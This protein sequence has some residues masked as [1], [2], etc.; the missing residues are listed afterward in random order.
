MSA[1]FEYRTTFARIP[2]DFPNH[3]RISEDLGHIAPKPPRSED[4]QLVTATTVVTDSGPVIF[5]FWE[6]PLD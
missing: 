2:Q 5:Y 4:W 1:R 3:E 6:R